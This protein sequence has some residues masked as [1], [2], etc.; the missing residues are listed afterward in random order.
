MR[1]QLGEV[2]P[3]VLDAMLESLPDAG[4]QLVE[5]D[6]LA[7]DDADL[8]ETRLQ[9]HFGRVRGTELEEEVLEVEHFQ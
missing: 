4:V 7:G 3:G 9:L 8:G 2:L 6:Y 1:F 5:L